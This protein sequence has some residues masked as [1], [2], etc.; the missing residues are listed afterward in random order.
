MALTSLLASMH[1]SGAQQ[2]AGIHA[3]AKSISAYVDDVESYDAPTELIC[4]LASLGRHHAGTH[5]HPDLGT[6][7]L[8]PMNALTPSL[9]FSALGLAQSVR[10][11]AL[12]YHIMTIMILAKYYLM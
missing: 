2:R 6:S 1:L 9:C 11:G 12:L 4:L 8:A 7:K 10:S 3:R 5:E